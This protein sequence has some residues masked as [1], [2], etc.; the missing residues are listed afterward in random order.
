VQTTIDYSTADIR[1]LINNVV[2]SYLEKTNQ[3]IQSGT[4]D[5][6]SKN[7]KAMVKSLLR[8]NYFGL[9]SVEELAE[10]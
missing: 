2:P 9:Q 1:K 5:A 3:F 4:W 6:I 7:S 8:I 10:S